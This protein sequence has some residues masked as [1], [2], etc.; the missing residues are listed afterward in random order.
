[1]AQYSCTILV[2]AGVKPVAAQ[3]S[4]RCFARIEIGQKGLAGCPK[5]LPISFVS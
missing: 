1:M 5:L 4:I 3:F 2:V